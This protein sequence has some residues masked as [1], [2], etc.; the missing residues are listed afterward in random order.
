MTNET[1]LKT[2]WRPITAIVYLVICSFDFILAPILWTIIQAY[3]HGNVN[4]QWQPLTLAGSGLFH[5]SFG[6]ILGVSAFTRG[7]EKIAM[8]NTGYESTTKNDE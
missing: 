5:I 8:V 7:Q 1:W 2:K 4:S 6:A 3:Y